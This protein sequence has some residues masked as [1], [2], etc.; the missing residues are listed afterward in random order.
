MMPTDLATAKKAAKP[1][2][3]ASVTRTTDDK[4]RKMAV[5]QV[6]VIVRVPSPTEV[7]KNISES[8]SVVSRLTTAISKPG[9]RLNIKASTPVYSVDKND[10]DLIVRKRGS[11][12]TR[13]HFD[14][15]GVFV[16]VK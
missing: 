4:T 15:K 16:K 14:K 10:P 11:Q 3:S 2:R 9:V 8:R 6:E 12:T 5:G 7:K 13:G 1:L